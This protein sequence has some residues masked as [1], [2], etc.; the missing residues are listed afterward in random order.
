MKQTGAIESIIHNAD[1]IDVMRSMPSGFVDMVF[2]DPPFN[3]NKKYRSYKDNISID[4]Y[5]DWTREWLEHSCRILKPSGNLLVYNLP[6]L[7]VHAASMLNRQEMVF[8]HWISWNSSGRPLGKTL[9]PAHYGILF[10]AKSGSSKFHDIRVPHKVCKRCRAYCRDYGGKEY[11]RHPF[12][13]LASDVW[14]DIHRVRHSSRRIAA[15]PCQLPVHL[16]ERIILMTTDENDIVFDPF[17]GGGS[18]AVAAKQMGRKYIGSEIDKEYRE[19]AQAK[20]QSAQPVKLNGVHV[21][22]HGGELISVRDMD[23]SALQGVLSK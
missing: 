18:A 21:S 6:R 10:Y 1:C 19:M 14:D 8:R 13:H 7:L 5:N 2:A 22:M 3:L 20:L 4:A 15:H 17:A 9:Q 23:I 11:R 16:I 12:G